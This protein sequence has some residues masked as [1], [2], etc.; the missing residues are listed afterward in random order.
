MHI[1]LVQV[2][3]YYYVGLHAL[4]NYKLI[5]KVLDIHIFALILIKMILLIFYLC[6]CAKI[7][8]QW[9]MRENNFNVISLT[10]YCL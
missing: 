4:K 6:F 8:R 1:S 7:T 2:R 5:N 9:K 3:Q 10:V